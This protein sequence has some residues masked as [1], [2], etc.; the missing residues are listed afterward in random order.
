MPMLEK[1]NYYMQLLLMTVFYILIINENLPASV[2]ISHIE[3]LVN[4]VFI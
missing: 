1:L 3:R 2:E 4:N